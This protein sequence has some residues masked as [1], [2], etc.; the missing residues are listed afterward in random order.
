MLKLVEPFP[1]SLVGLVSVIHD[2][3]LA[4]VH[5]QPFGAVTVVDPLDAVEL[6]VWLDGLIANVHGIAACVTVNVCPP[7]VSVPWR[8]DAF[9]F[10]A[11]ANDVEPL[12]LPLAPDVMVNHVVSL[13]AAVHAQPFGVVMLVEP[14]PPAATTD[15][16]T[17]F[18]EKV[19]PAAA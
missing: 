13:L 11:T 5:A 10:A 9:G 15:W 17:G 2:A 19:Q 12:P 14:L 3:L 4:A 8:C 1:S 7:I 16:L 6:T 18:S